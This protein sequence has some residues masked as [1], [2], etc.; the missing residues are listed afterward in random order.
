[1]GKYVEFRC[2]N[3]GFRSCEMGHDY[4]LIRWNCAP[5]CE[6]LHSTMKKARR[7]KGRFAKPPVYGSY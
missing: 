7:L 3:S 6:T 1:M 4:G 2:T 5:Q